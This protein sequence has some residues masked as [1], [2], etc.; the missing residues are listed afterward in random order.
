MSAI[1]YNWSA[2][3]KK[4]FIQ[5]HS[6]D[7]LDYHCLGIYKASLLNFVKELFRSTATNALQRHDGC[8]M[9]MIHFEQRHHCCMSRFL[10]FN[11]SRGSHYLCHSA[12]K[13]SAPGF[14]WLGGLYVIRVVL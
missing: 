10:R 5:D 2:R 7:L 8:C 13:D 4:S 9:T 6:S 1:F 3:L 11:S 14:T 12:E